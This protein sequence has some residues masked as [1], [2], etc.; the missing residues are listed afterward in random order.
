M[1]CFK[2][3]AASLGASLVVHGP[4]R[5]PHAG[6]CFV[7]KFLAPGRPCAAARD[8]SRPSMAAGMD[9]DSRMDMSLE[10]ISTR[11]SASGRPARARS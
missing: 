5:A 4:S 7:V 1:R 8:S 10:S 9:V 2:V 6:V 11:R 3:S